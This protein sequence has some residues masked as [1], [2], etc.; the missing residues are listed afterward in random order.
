MN[1]GSGF[2][3]KRMI[4]YTLLTFLIFWILLGLTGLLISLKA[5][6]VVQ[7][8]M[9]NVCAWSPTFSI[10][11]LF[12]KLYPDITLKEYLKANFQPKAK[13]STYIICFLLQFAILFFA[14]IVYMLMNQNNLSSLKFIGISSILPTLIIAITGGATGEELGWR[15][16]MLNEFQKKYSLLISA[17]STGFIWGIWHFPLWLLSGYKGIELLIYVISFMTSIVSFSILLSFFY[18]KGRNIL[19]AMWFHFLFNLSLRIVQIDI[20]Q[21]LGY[22]SVFLSI[23]SLL[24]VILK[25][26]RFFR[27][28]DVVYL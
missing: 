9:K 3:R 17:L 10:L 2:I 25:R 15:A 23:S 20:L 21:L 28:S 24:L 26:E 11:I 4:S 1:N 18:L 16:F 19:V 22:M 13:T 5:P 14:V 27:N 12:K 6:V 8:I 7:N